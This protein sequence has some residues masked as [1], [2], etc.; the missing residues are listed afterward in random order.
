[1]DGQFQC[2]PHKITH[3]SWLHRIAF[4]QVTFPKNNPRRAL[5]SYPYSKLFFLAQSFK[6]LLLFKLVMKDLITDLLD[7]TTEYRL[8]QNLPSSNRSHSRSPNYKH[9]WKNSGFIMD[10]LPVII[11]SL[12]LAIKKSIIMPPTPSGRSGFWQRKMEQQLPSSTGNQWLPHTGVS[13]RLLLL[14]AGSFISL[15]ASKAALYVQWAKFLL[16]EQDTHT[17]SKPC[18]YQQG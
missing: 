7:L 17:F 12:S 10:F 1:M 13:N 5:F 16:H 18:P 3:K 14:S 2:W 8:F 15:P 9:Y 11:Y 6:I 4:L